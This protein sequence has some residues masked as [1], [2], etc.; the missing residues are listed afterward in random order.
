MKPLDRDLEIYRVKYKG[1]IGDLKNGA[2]AGVP[3]PS[4]ALCR[5]IFS[6][7]FG[8][9]HVSVSLLNRCPTW[10]EMCWVKDKFFYPA[11][12]V[13]QY[14]PPQSGYVNVHPYCLHLWRPIKKDLPMPPNNF[15]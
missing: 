9:E 15:V 14:H 12:C 1:M 8:W 10:E 6:D 4:G 5:I 13:V 11:E 3:L 2:L 7:G